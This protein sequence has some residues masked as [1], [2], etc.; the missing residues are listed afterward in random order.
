VNINELA[1]GV[2]AATGFSDAD[3]KKAVAAVF[4]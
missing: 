1:K 4:E 2:A 3:A